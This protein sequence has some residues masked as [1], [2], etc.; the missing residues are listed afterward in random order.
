MWARNC[1]NKL[2][3]N[4]SELALIFET[5]FEAFEGLCF[6]LRTFVSIQFD[7]K[8]ELIMA[9]TASF[10]FCICSLIPCIHDSLGTTLHSQPSRSSNVNKSLHSAACSLIH[11]LLH[12]SLTAAS[13]GVLLSLSVFYVQSSPMKLLLHK[14]AA[15]K[16]PSLSSSSTFALA[17]RVNTFRV[18]TSA[19]I[20]W[21]TPS[22]GGVIWCSWRCFYW[23]TLWRP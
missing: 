9:S 16:A 17:F 21:A 7:L 23:C 10:P 2:Q 18:A 13:G 5:F 4:H 1:E 6:Q 11:K 14:S 15:C 19:F 20:C 22:S 3:K 12:Q 8:I